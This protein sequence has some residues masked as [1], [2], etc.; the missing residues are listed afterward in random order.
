MADA[1]KKAT[2]IYEQLNKNIKSEQGIALLSKIK[3]IRAE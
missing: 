1:G 3:Q 2:E